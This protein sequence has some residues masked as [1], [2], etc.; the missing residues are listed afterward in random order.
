MITRRL[1]S[2]MDLVLFE[3]SQSPQRS[4]GRVFLTIKNDRVIV[5]R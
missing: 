5:Q 1:E 3:F 4:D 2:L